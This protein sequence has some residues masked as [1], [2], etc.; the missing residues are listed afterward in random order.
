[1][2][3]STIRSIET[4]V[5]ELDRQSVDAARRG[6]NP[7]G[8]FTRFDYAAHQR[9]HKGVVRID[10]QPRAAL[11]VPS[12]FGKNPPI[13]T[14]EVAGETADLAM[15]SGVGQRHTERNSESL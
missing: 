11:P 12:L 3:A 6:R 10:G 5:L 15:E 2:L 7:V 14:D 1:M 13:G 9:I 8:E 4:D